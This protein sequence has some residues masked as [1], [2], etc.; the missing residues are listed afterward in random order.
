MVR[1]IFFCSADCFR[2]LDC[3]IEIFVYSWPTT[4]DPLYTVDRKCCV[5][6]IHK[7]AP[8]LLLAVR[9]SCAHGDHE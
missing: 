2:M 7:Q 4:V 8:R 1:E 6:L 5:A 9:H 3:G